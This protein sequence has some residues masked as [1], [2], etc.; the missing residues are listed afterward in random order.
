[1]V[2]APLDGVPKVEIN[3]NPDGSKY[4]DIYFAGPIRAA[5]GSSTV[6]PLILG[7]YARQYLKLDRYKPTQDELERYVEEIGIYQTEVISRQYTMKD[8]EIRIIITGSPVC[9][10]G[11]PTEE[12]E[13]SAHRD[14][15][16]IPTNRIRGGMGLV[17]AEGL[18]LKALWVMKTAKD[19][20]LN[21]D[22]LEK[23]VKVE[24][25]QSKIEVKPNKAYLDRLAA[26]RPI[27]AYPS[28]WG[29]FR[30]RYGKGRNTE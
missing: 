13:V 27:L 11:P 22:F 24:K 7:D 12:V 20:G 30:L 28:A 17:V 3:T 10:N 21:W 1:M 4:I 6:I 25:T 18:A 26:G 15:E 29:G 2:V 14:L 9:I 16:R 5:G 19:M 23:I 8:E